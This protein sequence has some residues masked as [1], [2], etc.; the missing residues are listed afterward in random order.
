MIRRAAAKRIRARPGPGAAYRPS[1]R[2]TLPDGSQEL[3]LL[4]DGCGYTAEDWSA[5]RPSSWEHRV[6]GSWIRRG[7]EAPI[8]VEVAELAR[9]GPLPRGG[10]VRAV[11]VRLSLQEHAGAA[12]LARRRAVTVTDVVRKGLIDQL[13]D[14][15]DIDPPPGWEDRAAARF[16]GATPGASPGPSDPPRAA[17]PSRRARGRRSSP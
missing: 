4:V 1:H 12:E 10:G 6:D 2:L 13:R 17:S 3:V 14:L 16:A 9:R 5:R 15:P 8:P 7:D 11:T